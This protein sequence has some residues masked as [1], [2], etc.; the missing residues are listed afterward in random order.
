MVSSLGLVT[1]LAKLFVLTTQRSTALGV[2]LQ[3]FAWRLTSRIPSLEVP[4]EA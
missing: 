1:K 3:G 4:V 2:I